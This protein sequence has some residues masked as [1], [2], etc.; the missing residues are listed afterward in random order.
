MYIVFDKVSTESF[1]GNLS[2]WLKG[3]FTGA[4]GR[5]KTKEALILMNEL[6][7]PELP[8]GGQDNG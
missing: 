2:L 5:S 3:V 1:T 8:E 7:I 4:I 6:E